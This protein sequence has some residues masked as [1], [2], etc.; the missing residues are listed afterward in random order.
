MH[1]R[2]YKHALNESL[3]GGRARVFISFGGLLARLE[4]EPRDFEGI[5]LDAQLY[6]LIKRAVQ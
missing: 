1:G 4:G 5:E 2:V 6:L 3:G